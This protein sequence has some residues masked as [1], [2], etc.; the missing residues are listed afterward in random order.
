MQL[1]FEVTLID[2]YNNSTICGGSIINTFLI[3][4][5]ARCI[6]N[7]MESFSGGRVQ[8]AAGRGLHQ[9]R[10][11]ISRIL[12]HQNYDPELGLLLNDVAILV[13]KSG[14]Q[15]NNHV[16]PAKFPKHRDEVPGELK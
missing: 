1:P 14:L 8:V 10:R 4:T 15:F 3:L 9:K 12:V 13:L 2:N 16:Q 11:N 5:A 7:N 6:S